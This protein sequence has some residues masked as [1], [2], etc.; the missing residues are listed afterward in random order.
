M[1][2]YGTV[3]NVCGLEASEE[4]QIRTMIGAL[5]P[6]ESY[7]ETAEELKGLRFRLNVIKADRDG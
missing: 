1:Q 7:P 5:K 4:T 6:Y 2:R 3:P